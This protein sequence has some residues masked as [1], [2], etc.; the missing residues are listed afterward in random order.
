MINSA[1]E[2]VMKLM[3]KNQVTLDFVFHVFRTGFQPDRSFAKLCLQMNGM[4]G[5]GNSGGLA[6]MMSKCVSK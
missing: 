6:S 3:V 4:I 1:A 2:T 5:G